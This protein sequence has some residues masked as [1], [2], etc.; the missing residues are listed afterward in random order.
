MATEDKSLGHVNVKIEQSEPITKEILLS[1][2]QVSVV[3]CLEKT[4]KQQKRIKTITN[5]FFVYM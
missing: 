5:C 1:Y 4:R 2:Q 3:Q